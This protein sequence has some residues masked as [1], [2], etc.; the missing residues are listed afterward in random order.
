MYIFVI[1]QIYLFLFIF[2]LHVLFS[3]ILTLVYAFMLANWVLEAGWA[4]INEPMYEI[5]NNVVF[6]TSKA[7][8]QPAHTQSDQSLCKSLEFFMIVKRLT[9]HHLESV[10]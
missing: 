2:Y 3:L 7:S 9:G 6:A 5:S 4:F 8:D 10:A 1:F